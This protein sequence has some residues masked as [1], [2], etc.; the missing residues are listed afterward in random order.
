[1]PDPVIAVAGQELPKLRRASVACRRF[2][3]SLYE[4]IG[5]GS[6]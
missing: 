1:M 6:D 2:V 3:N 4:E 5:Q